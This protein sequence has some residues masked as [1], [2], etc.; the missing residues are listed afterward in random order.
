M[1][2][3]I[4]FGGG[5]AASVARTALLP[6]ELLYRA[7]GGVRGALYDA[8]VLP[9]RSLGLPAVSVGNLS[10]GGTGKTPVSAWIAAELARRGARPAIVLRGYGED[11]PLVHA[12]L[13]P[14]VPV[15]VDA[16]RVRGAEQARSLG[17]DVVVLDDA[18]QHRRARRDA[19]IVLVSA[20]QPPRG[21]RLL[22]AG[23]WREPPRALRRA[24]LLVVTRKA[25]SA[26]SAEAV[27]REI[28]GHAPAVPSS[29]VHLAADTLR[30]SHGTASQP[31]ATLAGKRVFAIAAIGDPRAF[32]AQLE[33]AGARVTG[34]PH[35][36]HHRF[37]PDET[38]TLAARGAG[39]DLTVCTLKDAVKLDLH[40]PREAP[41]LWYVS[42]HVRPEQGAAELTALLD[43]LLRARATHDIDPAGRR[44]GAT[45]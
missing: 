43:R 38:R 15:V 9:A 36:D 16:D 17:A 30:A 12:A 7:A 23:P 42:Q 26:E 4:W 39:H 19:D 8:G 11:E 18:F 10:V 13:N 32:F 31:L 20:D 37:T 28:A 5:P 21:F 22:P 44:A 45:T 1:I 29:V 2:Q 35:G 25:A 41:T 27:R 24:S 34:A 14:T 6:L 3:R 33:E 40:W